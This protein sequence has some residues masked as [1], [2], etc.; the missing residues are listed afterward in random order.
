M[1]ASEDEYFV[2]STFD[3]TFKNSGV[4]SAF[5]S[6][7]LS[8]LTLYMTLV[9]TSD[10]TE[11]AVDVTELLDTVYDDVNVAGAD[12]MLSFIQIP[13]LEAGDYQLQIIVPKGHWTYTRQ[14]ETCLNFRVVLEYY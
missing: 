8:D 2:Y 13:S 12:D 4:F 7:R 5:A 11:I 9:R 1:T 6:Y 3:L 14:F 10:G